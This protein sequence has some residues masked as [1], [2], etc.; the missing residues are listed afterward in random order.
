M[1]PL[2]SAQRFTHDPCVAARHG[3]EQLHLEILR[4]L[5]ARNRRRLVLADGRADHGRPFRFFLWLRGSLRVRG[6]GEGDECEEQGDGL[7]FHGEEERDDEKSG[8][9]SRW[10]FAY[11]ATFTFRKPAVPPKT[12]KFMPA[13]FSHGTANALRIA[14]VAT[15]GGGVCLMTGEREKLPRCEWR[16]S[17]LR[18][19]RRPF[20]A[21]PAFEPLLGELGDEFGVLRVAGDVHVFLRVGLLV[22]ELDGVHFGVVALVDPAREAVAVGAHRV[23]HELLSAHAARD[24]G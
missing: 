6:G 11:G 17:T 22:V 10:R 18:S 12:R 7:G 21:L 3:V 1:R 14:A 4:D 19:G 24:T 16:N 8:G 9:R 2:S 15:S 23:A 5:D 20:C 13:I